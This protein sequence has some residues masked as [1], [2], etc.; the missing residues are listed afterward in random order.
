MHCLFL[1]IPFFAVIPESQGNICYISSK[2]PE[3]NI[4]QEWLNNIPLT[5]NVTWLWVSI[6]YND[7]TVGCRTNDHTLKM[8]VSGILWIHCIWCCRAWLLI[9]SLE[10]HLFKSFQNYNHTVKE[11]KNRID[12]GECK[13]PIPPIRRQNLD[14]LGTYPSIKLTQLYNND[15]ILFVWC[16]S[17]N[18]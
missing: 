13:F 3:P 12:F 6:R 1:L 10:Y 4:L 14:I 9:Y 11:L 17:R 8:M 15:T 2:G 7:G 16:I 18:S 5:G